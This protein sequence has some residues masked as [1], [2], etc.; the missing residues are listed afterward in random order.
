MQ[1]RSVAKRNNTLAEPGHERPGAWLL[2][3]FSVTPI[4]EQRRQG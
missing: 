2:P 1:N 3:Q 4:E